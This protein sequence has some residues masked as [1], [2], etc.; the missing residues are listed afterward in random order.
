MFIFSVINMFSS[1]IYFLGQS[2]NA[3]FIIQCKHLW[4]GK[5]KL[6]NT[7]YACLSFPVGMGDYATCMVV[8]ILRTLRD[9]R[10]LPVCS[11]VNAR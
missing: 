4:D 11:S 7:I 5:K 10:T 2:S 8:A 9:L 6:Q 3:D 1:V